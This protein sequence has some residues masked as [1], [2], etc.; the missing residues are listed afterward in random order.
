MDG[1]FS[2][3]RKK[4]RS[5]RSSESTVVRRASDRRRYAGAYAF[6]VCIH[7][8]AL[9]LVVALVRRTVAGEETVSDAQLPPDATIAVTLPTRT[10]APPT[11]A[12]AP[13]VAAPPPRAAVPYPRAH[14]VPLAPHE[15]A[16]NLLSAPPQPPVPAATPAPLAPP[17]PVIASESPATEPP[18]RIAAVAS[19]APSAA[20]T[21]PPTAEPTV[22]PTAEPSRLPTPEP[23]VRP[24][25]EPTAEPTLRA[26]AEPTGPPTPAPTVVTTAVPPHV[27][28]AI[29][30][31]PRAAPGSAQ[32]P[33]GAAPTANVTS[34]PAAERS[35]AGERLPNVAYASPAAVGSRPSSLNDRLKAALPTAP[36]AGL[37]RYDLGGYQTD[38]ILDAYEAQLAP[39]LEILAKTFGLLYTRRTAFQADSV[40]YVY[41][42]TRNLLGQ[43]V[44]K[45]YTIVEHPLRTAPPNTDHIGPAAAAY[46]GPPRDLKPEITTQEISCSARGMIKIVPGSMTSPAPRHPDLET[47]SPAP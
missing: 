46:P 39:P 27:T 47:P 18:L 31:I 42:R 21:A 26:S 36:T 7:V 43:E 34:A 22:L 45:A 41:E 37:K 20:A 25:F 9:V 6:S 30:A 38:R 44:C 23:T 33:S 2:R 19:A 1:G 28:A 13:T 14:R 11:P 4:R 8:L 12:P 32:G 16:R 29:A 10:P 15:L 17:A 3:R 24:T 5:P 40:A 35:A